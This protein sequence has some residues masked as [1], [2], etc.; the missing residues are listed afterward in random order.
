MQ[1]IFKI[2]G[3]DRLCLVSDAIRFAGRTQNN[4][5]YT[6]GSVTHI[7]EDGVAKLADRSAFAGSIATADHLIKKTVEM[8][9]SLPNAVKMMSETPAKVM[10]LKSKGRI[11]PGFDAD[12]TVLNEDLSACQIS[13]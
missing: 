8:G 10:G 3:A 4:F 7:I 1:M 2:K 5:S 6:K 13:I 9:I 12:F 11:A